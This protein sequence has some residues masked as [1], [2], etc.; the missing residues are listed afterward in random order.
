MPSL[1]HEKRLWADGLLRVVGVDEVG[2]AAL[3]GPVVA[4]ACLVTPDTRLIRKVNDSKVLTRLQ[5]ED[6]FGAIRGRVVKVG[7]GAASVAEIHRL[8]IYHASHVAMLRALRQIGE[9][10]WVLVDGRRILDPAF[11]PGKHSEIVRGDAKSFSIASASIVAKVTRDRL[12]AK[13]SAKYPGYGWEHNCGYPTID[14]R[15]A[16][17]ELGVTPFHRQ[18]FGTVRVMLSAEQMALEM[19]ELEAVSPS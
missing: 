5:R 6:L 11:A 2:M 13:L 14:H 18:D 16:L 9:Y 17:R 1:N 10:D 15:K 8:N 12:M 3:A 19:D 4:A 7:V